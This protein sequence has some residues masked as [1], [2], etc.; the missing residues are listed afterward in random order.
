VKNP[1]ALKDLSV[2]S[3]ITQKIEEPLKLVERKTLVYCLILKKEASS[4]HNNPT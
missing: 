3:F 1:S 4:V 2:L